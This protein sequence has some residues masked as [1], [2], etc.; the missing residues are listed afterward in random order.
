MDPSYLS[1]TIGII[2]I[3]LALS[4]FFS[5]CETAF[6]SLSKSSLRM[7][8]SQSDKRSRRVIKL[9]DRPRALLISLL[10]GNTLVNTAT[11]SLTALLVDQLARNAG[12]N[13]TIAL[14]L[15]IV[16]VSFI[17]IVTVEITPKIIAIKSNERWTLTATTL[18][19]FFMFLFY[20]ITIVL[21]A[22]VEKL[23]K[24]FGLES[25][26]VL[27]SDAELRT[28]AEVAEEHGA[29]EENEREMIHSIF[30]FGETEAGEVMIPRI[31]MVT[32]SE[33]ASL[34]EAIEL[35]Q[36]HGHSRIP[37][38]RENVD[39]IVGI[40]Y[41]KDLIGRGGEKLKIAD[42]MRKADFVPG[43]RRISSLLKDFQQHNRH[44]AIVV[45]EYGGTE[46]LVTLEDVIE[47]IVGE[48]QDEYDQEE[49]LF[50]RLDSKVFQ[51]AA[52]MEV[53]DFNHEI[54]EELVP[55]EDDYETLGGFIF[56]LAGV[57]PNPGQVF[58]YKGWKFKAEIVENNRVVRLIITAPEDV[59]PP[60]EEDEANRQDNV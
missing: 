53:E 55:T 42:L 20:P 22:F 41:A 3:L 46:G 4:A 50:K 34:P 49:I 17:L 58:T 33:D 5:G 7:L 54:D 9:L 18:L 19:Q 57:V 14:I 37:V 26:R 59:I 28:L 48:I 2:I 12:F 60:E 11:A 27:F 44:M 29:L 38:Y 23:A 6:F 52:K 36:Q 25:Q 13:T 56:A 32:I 24:S 15:Q 10:I 35:V 8:H 40:L 39:H 1:L 30:E 16:V 21:D 51:V 45:D 47:E 31:D 43:S